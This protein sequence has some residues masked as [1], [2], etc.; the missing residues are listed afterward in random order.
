MFYALPKVHKGV[1]SLKGRPIVLGIDGLM[2][3]MGIYIDKILQTFV[4]AFP[5]LHKG[6]YGFIEKI[7]RDCG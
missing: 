2:Q 5:L 1:T 4:E 6:H 3:N 7:G